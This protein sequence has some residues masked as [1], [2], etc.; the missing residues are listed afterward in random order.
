MNRR[1]GLLYISFPPGGGRCHIY[2]VHPSTVECLIPRLQ[3]EC[4]RGDRSLVSISLRGTTK[5]YGLILN[6]NT[7]TKCKEP[8][9]LRRPLLTCV[10]FMCD[11]VF[12]DRLLEVGSKKTSTPSPSYESSSQTDKE[13]VRGLLFHYHPPIHPSSETSFVTRRKEDR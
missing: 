6:P 11:Y 5:D 12:R 4:R 7:E 8:G 10:S 3:G 9:T 13:Y 1:K 2:G